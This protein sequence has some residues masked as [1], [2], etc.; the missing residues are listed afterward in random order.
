MGVFDFLSNRKKDIPEKKKGQ[1]AL[2]ENVI[3]TSKPAI[4]AF[5]MVELKPGVILP[6]FTV[7]HWPE[8]EGT[9]LPSVAITAVPLEEIPPAAS[10]FG[11]YPYIP[12]GFPYPKDAGGSYM[13]PLAQINFSEVPPVDGFPRSGYLQIYISAYDQML[14]SDYP[15]LQSQK[16]FRIFFLEENEIAVHQTDFSFLDDIMDSGTLPI[17]TSHRLSFTEKEDHMGMADVRVEMALGLKV[18]RMIDRIIKKYP[19]EDENILY[20]KFCNTFSGRGHKI[21]G[22]A[23]FTQTDPRFKNPP[24]DHYIL[25]LQIDSDEEIMWGEMGV[26]HFFIHPDD[27]AKKDF[28]KVMYTWDNG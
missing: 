5:E 24:F 8:I 4:A 9:G 11:G 25:L 7:D 28:S 13:Y 26:A 14:G 22:Y 2:P 27:L 20:Q 16:N 17:Q 10:K 23:G 1:E 12:V 21:G 3:K 18:S 6:G 15:D 19:D